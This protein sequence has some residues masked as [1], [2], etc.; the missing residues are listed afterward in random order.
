MATYWSLN[1]FLLYI[2]THETRFEKYRI[3]KKKPKVMSQPEVV[4]KLIS[5]TILNTIAF[6]ILS[7]LMYYALS[8]RGKVVLNEP[9]PSLFTIILQLIAFTLVEDFLFFWTHYAIHQVPWIYQFMHKE[10]HSFRQPIGLVATLADPAESIS[11][12]QLTMWL[13][14]ALLPEKHILTICLWIFIRVQQTVSSH[15]GYDLPFDLKHYFP[16]LLSGAPV[17]DSHHRI[18][19]HNYGSFFTIW[20]RIMGTYREPEPY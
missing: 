13:L 17:H 19:K 14:P 15:S 4:K 2:D 1:I 6:I 7:P 5:G 3:Q 18:G 16:W 8:L 12:N 11:Q 10:H 20:D 9:A